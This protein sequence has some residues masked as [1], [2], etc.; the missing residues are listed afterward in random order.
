[1]QLMLL[2]QQQIADHKHNN[3]L[4]YGGASMGEW[5]RSN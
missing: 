3:Q 4:V 2:Q 1:M 5:H